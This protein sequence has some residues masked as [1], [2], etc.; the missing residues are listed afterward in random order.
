[1]K[2]NRGRKHKFYI[3]LWIKNFLKE[4][5]IDFFKEAEHDIS[6]KNGS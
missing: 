2:A 3:K 6:Q 4:K 5:A 1:L